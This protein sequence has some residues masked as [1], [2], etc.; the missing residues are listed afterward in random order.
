L[1]SVRPKCL[2]IR[3]WA[4]RCRRLQTRATCFRAFLSCSRFDRISRISSSAKCSSETIAWSIKREMV[5]IDAE[6]IRFKSKMSVKAWTARIDTQG[7]YHV[8]LFKL[9]SLFSSN[10]LLEY[11]GV[12]RRLRCLQGS[13]TNKSN[14]L[15]VLQEV[16]I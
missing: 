8:T 13:K 5:M 16:D 7:S 12:W 4:R 9:S 14:C 11:C 15:L 6:P 3:G 2:T 10:S 1:L